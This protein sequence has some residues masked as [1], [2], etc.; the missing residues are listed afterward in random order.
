MPEQPPT[1]P[2]PPQPAQPQLTDIT[3]D[4][5]AGVIRLSFDTGEHGAIGLRELR[6]ACP[7][8]SCRRSREFGHQSWAPRSEGDLPT[9]AHAQLVGAWGLSIVWDDGHSTGIY[10]FSDLAEW[11]RTGEARPRPDSG[12]PG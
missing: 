11:V 5:P 7:C 2:P 6:L 1:E 8:A 9:V 10:A 3:I 12:L 4:R